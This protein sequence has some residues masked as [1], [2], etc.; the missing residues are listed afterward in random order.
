[1]ATAAAPLRARSLLSCVF[2]L[3]PWRLILRVF[4][5]RRLLDDDIG[6]PVG[7]DSVVFQAE[8]LESLMRRN[9]ARRE[10]RDTS[11]RKRLYSLLNKEN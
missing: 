9:A 3:W 8:A 6:D 1:M 11:R 2:I 7:R 5:Q 10:K 4:A